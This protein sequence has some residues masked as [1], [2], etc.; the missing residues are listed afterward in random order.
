VLDGADAAALVALVQACETSC[1]FC[2]DA[3]LDDDVAE[4][5]ACIRLC[6]LCADT[7]SLTSGTLSRTSPLPGD[8]ATALLNLCL[9]VC[10]ACA[11]ECE[12][13]DDEHCRDCA[14]AC[15]RCEHACRE[16]LTRIGDP[17]DGGR[18]VA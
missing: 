3:C 7:C 14:T 5:A 10:Q 16:A 12:L 18:G 4:M 15:R 9:L 1:R 11:E 13:H 6:R 17:A 8:V 2:A